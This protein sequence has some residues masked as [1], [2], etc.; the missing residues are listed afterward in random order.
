MRL[1]I[2]TVENIVSGC[3]RRLFMGQAVFPVQSA[4]CRDIRKIE[5]IYRAHRSDRVKIN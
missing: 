4:D 2:Y 3:Y 5:R 1:D